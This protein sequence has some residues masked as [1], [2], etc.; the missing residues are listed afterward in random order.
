VN[1]LGTPHNL[2]SLG[3]HRAQIP[4]RRR[5]L[6]LFPKGLQKRS[7][8]VNRILHSF[9]LRRYRRDGGVRRR[10]VDIRLPGNRYSTPH[11]TRPDLSISSLMKRKRTSWLSIQISRSLKRTE[12]HALPLVKRPSQTGNQVQM[13]GAYRGTSLIR[14]RLPLGPCSSPMPRVLWWS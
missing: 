8:C 4:T 10:R 5:N 9:F 2:A 14:K 1:L 3:A 13:D 12:R 7:V 6:V 11:D